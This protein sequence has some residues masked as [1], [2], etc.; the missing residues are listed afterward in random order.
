M[1][2]N[3]TEKNIFNERYEKFIKNKKML[4]VGKVENKD[5]S[6]ITPLA[7]VG[8]ISYPYVGKNNIYCAWRN[9]P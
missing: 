6:V 3:V 7:N 8:I 1:V 4:M 9:C 5:M 2:G